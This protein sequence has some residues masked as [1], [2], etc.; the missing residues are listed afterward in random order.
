MTTIVSLAA[1]DFIAVGCDSLAT[2]STELLAPYDVTS[3]YFEPN[4]D[5]KLD[6]AGKPLLQRAGQIWEKAKRMPIDQL[7]SVTK[8]YDLAPLNAC[9]LF[10]GTSRVGNITIA[11]IVDL[12]LAQKEI[13]Q[14]KSTYTLQWIAEKFKE[15]VMNLYAQEVPEKW[16]RQTME[17]FLSGYS[18]KHRQP[19]LWSL[20]FSYN[21][22]SADFECDVINRIPRGTYN[23]TFG[24]QYDVI[25]RVVNGIDSS[26]NFALRQ[27]TVDVLNDYHDDMQAKIHAIDP[28]ITIPKPSFWDKK[29]NLF[30]NDAGGVTRLFPDVGSLSDKRE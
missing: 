20:T 8:L 13:K 21:R 23:V 19:E 29:Y 3:I 6:A 17:V 18:A 30:E 22:Q 14:R 9:V 27:R 7:P 26:S 1:R 15:F 10:A 25:Q 12:F 4:G 24:G 28:K 2:T 5:L 16:A 11:H